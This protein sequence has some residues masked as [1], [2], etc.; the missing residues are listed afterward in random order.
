MQCYYFQPA[1]VTPNLVSEPHFWGPL[2]PQPS[3]TTTLLLSLKWIQLDISN[4]V[5][6]WIA[7][8]T[9]QRKV[10]CP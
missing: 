4:L 2:Q 8:S 7:P 6:R 1:S 9:S 5:R 10:N 3:M